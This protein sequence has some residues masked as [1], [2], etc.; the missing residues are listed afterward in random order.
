MA[1]TVNKALKDLRISIIEELIKK[2]DKL[3]INEELVRKTL[4]EEKPKRKQPN[5]PIDK[6][7]TRFTKTG[8]KCKVAI[9]DKENKI[10]WA[11]MNKEQRE[12]HRIK[13]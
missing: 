1:K 2:L 9:C 3:E 10:C 4:L 7:C 8:E 12:K 13:K 5:I 6:Q 11:H